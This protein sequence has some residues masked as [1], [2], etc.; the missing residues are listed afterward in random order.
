MIKELPTGKALAGILF[1][2]HT[3]VILCDNYVIS[4]P[5]RGTDKQF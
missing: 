4:T 3:L 5:K 1:I 2:A